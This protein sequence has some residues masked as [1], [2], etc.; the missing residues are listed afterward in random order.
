MSGSPADRRR[1]E[2]QSAQDLMDEFDGWSVGGGIS[3]LWF[4]RRA[5]SAL[6]SGESLAELRDAII[7]WLWRHEGAVPAP[8]A[9][10]HS[11]T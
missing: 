8:A 3:G 9:G 4:A 6:I 2:P 7:S 1:Y 11:Q 10:V 5:D